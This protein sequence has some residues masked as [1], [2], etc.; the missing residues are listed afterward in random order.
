MRK[1][2]QKIISNVFTVLTGLVIIGLLIIAVIIIDERG[3]VGALYVCEAIA[4]ILAFWA[5]YLGTKSNPT[6]RA[7]LL[8]AIFFF[9]LARIAQYVSL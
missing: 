3:K 6:I 7:I 9:V 1:S 2:L 4:G 5:A 8:P